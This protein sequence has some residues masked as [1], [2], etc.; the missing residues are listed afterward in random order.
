MRECLKVRVLIIPNGWP[1][2]ASLYFC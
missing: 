1:I 2:A